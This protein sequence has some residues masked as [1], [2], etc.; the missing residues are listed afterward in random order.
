MFLD[1]E[2]GHEVSFD[3]FRIL[4]LEEDRSW[5]FFAVD[6]DMQRQEP[7]GRYTFRNSWPHQGEQVMC[8]TYTPADVSTVYVD[9]YYGMLKGV[10]V[11]VT[12]DGFQ[13]KTV[14]VRMVEE[15]KAGGLTVYSKNE[16][17]EFPAYSVYPSNHV[18]ELKRTYSSNFIVTGD[19]V[20][21]V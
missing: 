3:V 17:V 6:F 11:S 4:H 8:K 16:I 5:T 10:P 2:V 18:K 14:S 19:F 7:C 15:V 20:W 12:L 1:Q 13:K 21:A 9:S